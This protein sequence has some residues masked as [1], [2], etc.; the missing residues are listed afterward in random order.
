MSACRPCRFPLRW[1]TTT[2]ADRRR[3]AHRLF[4]MA[5]GA[6]DLVVDRRV[7]ARGDRLA[8][9]AD[10]RLNA[11]G[12]DLAGMGGELPLPAAPR[13]RRRRQRR[14]GRHRRLVLKCAGN[15]GRAGLQWRGGSAGLLAAMAISGGV[16]FGLWV[17]AV[18]S[19]CEKRYRRRLHLALPRPTIGVRM[20]LDAFDD[21]RFAS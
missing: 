10:R 14:G 7:L 18:C 11:G 5:D 3:M 12:V 20:S 17:S 15:A 16:V 2:A 1:L 6:V 9:A 21:G 4:R 13:C 19:T 8:D